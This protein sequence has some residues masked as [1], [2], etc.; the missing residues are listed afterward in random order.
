[1]PTARLVRAFNTV[2]AEVMINPRFENGCASTFVCADDRLARTTVLSLARDIGF[3]AV[4]AGPLKSACA[5]DR[6]LAVWWVLAFDAGLGGTSPSS[7]SGAERGPGERPLLREP[8]LDPG[9]PGLRDQLL[10][11]RLEALCAELGSRQ[12]LSLM[13][14]WRWVIR[15]PVAG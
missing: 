5:V 15:S 7:C 6:L 9:R 10:L 14:C 3:D 11:H 2:P 1:M 13:Y 12:A 8:G 4:D